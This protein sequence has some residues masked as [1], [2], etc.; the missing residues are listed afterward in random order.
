M[1]D[2][3]K[4]VTISLYLSDMIQHITFMGIVLIVLLALILSIMSIVT[5]N[6]QRAL[7]ESCVSK[8]DT[9]TEEISVISA[10]KTTVDSVRLPFC[11]QEDTPTVEVKSMEYTVPDI[12]TSVK[13]FTDYRFYNLTG[14]PHYRLQ[15]RCWTDEEGCRRFNDDYCVAVGSYYSTRIGDRFEVEFENG[16]IITVI[17]AD[18]KWDS[19]CDEENMY[20][21]VLNYDNEMCGN[22]L[23]FIVDCDVLKIDVLEYGSLNLYSSLEGSVK[24]IE[25]LERDTSDDWDFY[26]E[27]WECS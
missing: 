1:K 4:Q 12:D 22:L 24:R 26:E 20:T 21:P 2:E 5:N 23:E 10:P 14:T 15:Q 9:L 25:L 7:F 17:V 3:R 27:G 16:R 18:G 6:N 8:I 13:L 19:D 11:R